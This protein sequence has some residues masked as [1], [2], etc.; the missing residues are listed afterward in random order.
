V[1]DVGSVVQRLGREW[2]R[3]RRRLRREL[4]GLPLETPATAGD[5]ASASCE[6][7]LCVRL[8]VLNLERELGKRPADRVLP[9]LRATV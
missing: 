9:H 5:C 6:S 4:P 1:R 3:D 8:R 2:R 7:G